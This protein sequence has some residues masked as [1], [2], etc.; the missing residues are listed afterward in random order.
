M[1]KFRRLEPLLFHGRQTS[2]KYRFAYQGQ[3]NTQLQRIDSSPFACTFLSCTIE[4]AYQGRAFIIDKIEYLRRNL[5]QVGIQYAR[6]PATKHRRHLHLAQAHTAPHKII[7]FTYQLHIAVLN[8]VMYH[9]DV[10]T[11]ATRADPVTAGL[12]IDS[13]GNCLKYLLHLWPGVR[14]T[15]GHDTGTQASPFF[16]PGDTGTDVKNA[17]TGQ[18][19]STATRV[20]EQF[21]ATIDQNVAWAEMR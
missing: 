12:I 2:G 4:N 8:T 15:S 13:S 19:Q 10:M 16:T 6:I 1:E 3:R 5:N 21:I 18:F 20:G 7:G 9:L 11:G 14:V 17:L